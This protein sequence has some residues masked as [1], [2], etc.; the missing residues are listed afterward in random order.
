M[1]S[2]GL[3]LATVLMLALA[4]PSAQRLPASVRIGT[5]RPGGGYTVTTIPLEKYVASVLA[6]EAARESPPAALEALGIAVRT[7]TLANLGRHRADGFDLCDETHCQ[8]TRAST[9]AT[10][11]AAAATAGRVLLTGGVPASIYYSASCGGHTERPSQVWPGSDDPAYL[12]AQPDDACGGAPAWSAELSADDLLRAL[13][14]GGFRGGRLAALRIASH[15]ESGRVARLQVDGLSPETISGQDL[16]VVV[17]RTLGWQFIKSTAFDLKRDGDRYRFT[18]HGSGHGVGMC[19]IGSTRLAAAGQS[20]D[21][22]LHRYFPGLLIAVPGALSE[23]SAAEATPPARAVPTGTPPPTV[24]ARPPARATVPGAPPA[25]VIEPEVLVSLPDGDEGSRGSITDVAVR[26]RTDLARA[27]GVPAPR[28]TLRFHPTID[29]YQ[30]ATREPWFTSGA[31]IDGEVHLPPPI[32]L[33]DRGMLER[34][35][36]HELVHVM[37]DGVLA[38]R[39]LWVREGAAIYF[40]GRPVV[41]GANGDVPAALPRTSCPA[42]V[43]LMRPVS[44]GALTTAYARAQACFVR[45]MAQGKSWRDVK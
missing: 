19:V 25:P 5:P 15:N 30:Q 3:S 18:G 9:A 37:T 4:A 28:V 35:I 42:D 8:V 7:F 12:P 40:A 29:S 43:E 17:G 27:L 14:G 11:R 21:D 10:E 24:T 39:P 36:R 38:G 31:L 6:G 23:L 34:T 26:A 45:Q 20:A 22:I 41:P 33:R 1:R 32:V 2:R 16:R 13:H 44:A